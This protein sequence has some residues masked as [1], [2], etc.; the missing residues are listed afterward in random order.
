MAATP[1]EVEND[2]RARAATRNLAHVADTQRAMLRGADTIRE[3]RQVVACLE[4][5]AEAAEQKYLDYF[6]G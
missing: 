4:E 2:L 5:A 6:Y 3:L 1:A